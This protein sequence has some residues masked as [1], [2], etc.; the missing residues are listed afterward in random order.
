MGMHD[1]NLLCEL[2]PLGAEIA[3]TA[4]DH[5]PDDGVMF[6]GDILFIDGTPIMWVGPVGNWIAAC[7]RM[8]ELG[9]DVVVPGHGPVTDARGVRAVR[10]YL[11]YVTRE[12]RARYDAGMPPLEA[13]RDIALGDF[14]SWGDAERIVVNTVTLYREFAGETDEAPG[15]VDLFATMA[16]IARDRRRA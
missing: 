15:T 10:D 3:F 4:A 12:A 6:T 7:D 8:L 5:L 16:E 9:V 14:D 11:E 13:A 2:S 1:A